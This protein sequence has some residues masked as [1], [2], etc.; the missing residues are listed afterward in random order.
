MI[1]QVDGGVFLWAVHGHQPL[2]FRQRI[3]PLCEV[4]QGKNFLVLEG[5]GFRIGHRQILL[6]ERL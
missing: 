5:I 4:Q 6:G 1:V 2:D 3:F